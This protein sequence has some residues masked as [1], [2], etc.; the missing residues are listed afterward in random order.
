MPTRLSLASGPILAERVS[1]A[2]TPVERARGL[3]G[4]APLEPGECLVIVRGTQVHTLGMAYP[5]D[6]LFCGRDWIVLHV[7]R[8]LRPWRASRWV[9]GARF[10]VELPSGV[11]PGDVRRGDRVV[12]ERSPAGDP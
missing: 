3:L 7:L 4:R 1:W 6:V 10:I 12:A 2:R 8:G 5:I 9:R 11:L